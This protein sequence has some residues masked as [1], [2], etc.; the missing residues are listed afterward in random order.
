MALLRSGRRYGNAARAAAQIGYRIV[1]PI[2]ARAAREVARQAGAYV[3]NNILHRRPLPRAEGPFGGGRLPNGRTPARR[4][5]NIRR[6]GAVS[7]RSAGF[8]R[9]RRRIGRR[10]NTARS[11]TKGL[12]KVIESGSVVTSNYC[13]YIGHHDMPLASVMEMVIAALI[14]K[15]LMKVGY[16]LPSYDGPIDNLGVGDVIRIIARHRPGDPTVFWSHNIVLGDT[17]KTITLDLVQQINVFGD[18]NQTILE[19]L[20]Y[21][22][23]GGNTGWPRTQMNLVDMKVHLKTKA[24]LKIQN[25]SKNALGNE[26]DEVD[27]V[28]LYGKSYSGTGSGFMVDNNRQL[29]QAYFYADTADGIISYD[30]ADDLREPPPAENTR[31]T[32]KTGKAKLDPGEVKTSVLSSKQTVSLNRFYTLAGRVLMGTNK[33]KSFLGKFRCF[34]LEKMIETEFGENIVPIAVAW[35]HNLRLECYVTGGSSPTIQNLEL[36]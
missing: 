36:R 4:G 22:P 7:S 35:E 8:F 16:S 26:A 30:G 27:N 9:S 3:R 21:D 18:Q 28:P 25:R 14:K 12:V 5:G 24:T 10:T 13:R 17:W 32:K 6:M 1:E 15:L 11:I 23:D 34:A 19:T 20:R 2:A 29:G 31:Q 33:N